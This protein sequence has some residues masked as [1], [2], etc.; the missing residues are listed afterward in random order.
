MKRGNQGG[1]RHGEKCRPAFRSESDGT[2]IIICATLV[3]PRPEK[4]RNVKMNGGDHLK[5]PLGEWF[6]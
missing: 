4:E 3:R 2:R 1:S 5:S 6:G